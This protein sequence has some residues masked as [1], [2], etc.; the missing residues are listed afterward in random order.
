MLQLIT[1]L[2]QPI[3]FVS[4]RLNR[5][6]S[7]ATMV[8]YALMVALIAIVAVLAV[9]FL[10]KDISNLFSNTASTVSNAGASGS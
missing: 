10:G 9:T 8:E 3:A 7:G 1:Y 2:M 5:E 4:G 6:E